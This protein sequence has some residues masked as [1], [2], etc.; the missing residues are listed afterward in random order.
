M[1]KLF[2][3]LSAAIV[4]IVP[5]FAEVVVLN[6]T[7]TE[8]EATATPYVLNINHNKHNK[9][10]EI[11]FKLN[12]YFLEDNPTCPGTKICTLPDF[13]SMA[14]EGWPML[15][16]K[17]MRYNLP[18]CDNPVIS[19]SNIATTEI[20]CEIS[21]AQVA[22]SGAAN[23]VIREVIDY[24]GFYPTGVCQ[25][26]DLQF[27]RGLPFHYFNITP[28]SYSS[29]D[30]K[31][32][33][34][35]S[36]KATISY[37][38]G[39][40]DLE[41]HRPQSFKI[42]RARNVEKMYQTVS[43]EHIDAKPYPVE[44]TED[45]L[46]ISSKMFKAAIDTLA[47]WKQTMGYRVHKY[48][49]WQIPYEEMDSVIDNAYNNLDNL[50]N[51]VIIGP[52]TA[53]EG[54][55]FSNYPK[56]YEVGDTALNYAG[57]AYRGNEIVDKFHDLLPEFNLGF[58]Y[59]NTEEE[60]YD[61]IHKLKKYETAPITDPSFYKNTFMASRFEPKGADDHWKDYSLIPTDRLFEEDQWTVESLEMLRPI[62]T[63]NGLNVKRIYNLHPVIIQNNEWPRVWSTKSEYYRE[64]MGFFPDYLKY[65]NFKWNGSKY[66]IID[67]FSEGTFLGTYFGHGNT[68]GW[69][70]LDF[71]PKDFPQDKLNDKFPLILSISCGTGYVKWNHSFAN[72]L[73]KMR[74]G[75]IGVIAATEISKTFANRFLLEGLLKELF[76]LTYL[77]GST[78]LPELRLGDL[79]NNGHLFAETK[80]DRY[81]H[82]I[83]RLTYCCYGDPSVAIHT[84]VPREYYRPEIVAY[85]P[86]IVVDLHDDPVK[87]PSKVHFYEPST[88]RVETF[89]YVGRNYYFEASA[90]VKDV[91]VTVTG[92]NRYPYTTAVGINIEES[93]LPKYEG[94]IKSA[95]WDSSEQGFILDIEVSGSVADFTVYFS[96]LN[97]L[98]GVTS[99]SN[100]SVYDQPYILR[101]CDDFSGIFEIKLVCDGILLDT[102]RGIY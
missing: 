29:R 80:T 97:E 67:S 38:E 87:Y 71:L 22:V 96:G 54:I 26:A 57:Y 64:R 84:S 11:D 42:T 3:L 76:P 61:F 40:A 50:T 37:N 7:M 6:N 47:E 14:K 77:S 18:T 59:V 33:I 34:T 85:G 101:V 23:D 92:R 94:K 72:W 1:K 79:L 63:E 51:V 62:V 78:Y 20:A 21:P 90:D 45:Y 12:A 8:A 5:T 9:T 39:L 65:P 83:Q 44:N 53:V 52:W 55:S 48:L 32:N 31:L 56:F 19:L 30:K 102:Y 43:W 2:Y 66:D 74:Q 86:N 89:D 46:I 99:V 75:A 28:F 41:V 49:G 27:Y 25:H 10:I 100:Q 82:Q 16:E 4:G 81:Y 93:Y 68:D 98:G 58:I 60:L 36:F 69:Y 17:L 91:L 95:T 15:P 24:P 73:M 88:G 13:V 70:T 35:T